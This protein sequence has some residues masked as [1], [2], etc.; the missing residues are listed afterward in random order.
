[1]RVLILETDKFI[2]KN[3]CLQLEASGHCADWQVDP[4]EAIISADV[5]PVDLVIMDVTLAGRSGIEFLY[6][7]RSYP[8]WANVPVIIFSNV[9]PREV[10]DSLAG[11]GQINVRHYFYKPTTPIRELVM[12]VDALAPLKV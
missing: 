4:Q 5:E 7:F 8:D 11:F 3:I 12:A 1:M 2:A 6:E 10:G 9:P